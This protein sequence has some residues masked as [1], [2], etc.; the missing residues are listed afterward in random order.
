M[1]TYF[2][3]PVQES[4]NLNR[5]LRICREVNYTKKVYVEEVWVVCYTIYLEKMV[6]Q[7]FMQM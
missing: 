2:H 7:W 5:L 4:L 6:G 1:L 3:V